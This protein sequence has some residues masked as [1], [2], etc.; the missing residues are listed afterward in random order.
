MRHEV[1]DGGGLSL[2][3][4]NDGAWVSWLFRYSNPVKRKADDPKK[5]KPDNMGLGPYPRVNLKK[6]REYAGQQWLIVHEGKDPRQ[7]RAEVRLG[8]QI[9]RGKA[10]TVRQ[11]FDQY[12]DDQIRGLEK[13]TQENVTAW[14]ENYMLPLIGDWPIQKVNR[15]TILDGL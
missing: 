5:G 11:A 1:S 7:E 9:A 10:I 15:K 13:V 6:A 12:F 8:Q 4:R 14:A 3:I 2:Q